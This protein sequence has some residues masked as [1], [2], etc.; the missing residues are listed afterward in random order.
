[1]LYDVGHRQRDGRERRR[2][3]VSEVADHVAGL[4]HQ[5]ASGHG[6][7][8][9]AASPPLGIAPVYASDT[10]VLLHARAERRGGRP[11]HAE[12][13]HRD[14]ELDVALH[15]WIVQRRAEPRLYILGGDTRQEP[16]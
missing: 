9:L 6:A 2:S 14:G 1:D 8:D 12:T 10:V 11:Q 5:D 13:G 15:G 3:P 4:L 7:P 16:T